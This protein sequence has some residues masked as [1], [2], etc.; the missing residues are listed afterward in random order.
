MGTRGLI[1][2]ID[3]ELKWLRELKTKD[4]FDNMIIVKENGNMFKF[5]FKD[6]DKFSFKVKVTYRLKNDRKL[7][8]EVFKNIIKDI[9]VGYNYGC[10]N[11][12]C[13]ISKQ[14]QSHID[15]FVMYLVSIINNLKS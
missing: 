11:V 1:N 12:I 9:V 8:I 7:G 4:R 2:T 15:V 10:G 5:E 13:D 14:E 6:I 3:K